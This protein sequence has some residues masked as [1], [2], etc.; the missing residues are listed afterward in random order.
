M[1]EV[2]ELVVSYGHVRAVRGVSLVVTEGQLVSMLGP[3]GAGKSSTVRAIAGSIRP[4]GGQVNIRGKN[5]T[6]HRAYRKLRDGVSLVPEGRG[7]I[8]PLSV[9]E[10]LLLGGY[11]SHDRAAARLRRDSL[12]DRFPILYERRRIPGGLLSGGEQQLLALA[13]SLMSEPDLLL[14]DEPTMGL[15]PIMVANVMETVASLRQAGMAILMVEQNAAASV[16]IS[17]YVY[18]LEEGE[19]VFEGKPDSAMQRH[20]ITAAFLGGE[21]PMPESAIG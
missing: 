7:I 8:A 11:R 20:A 12:L 4:A 10:N 16:P 3:N 2:N 5:T 9:E 13:R 6:R 17:D 14:L 18:V 19:I 1:L 21:S 15:A